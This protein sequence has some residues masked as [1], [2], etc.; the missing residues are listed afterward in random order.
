MTASGALHGVLVSEASG[1]LSG[2]RLDPALPEHL[3]IDK[4]T[5]P[6]PRRETPSS[7]ASAVLR[8]GEL[9]D[10]LGF[11]MRRA[12]VRTEQLF[13][14][15]MGA[16]GITSQLY[17]ILIVIDSNPGCRISDLCQAVGVSPNNIGPGLDALL[18]RGLVFRDFSSRDRRTK[19]LSLTDTGR[20]QLAELRR[21]HQA[22]TDELGRL[23]DSSDLATLLKLL[24]VVAGE[25][26]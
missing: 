11:V 15:H 20:E 16:T 18:D 23:L 26:M 21:M 10:T 22:I 8:R 7:D 1:V 9:E 13:N 4:A 17:A 2:A 25:G 3:V 6:S 14:Q 24:K 12:L 5:G 19:R